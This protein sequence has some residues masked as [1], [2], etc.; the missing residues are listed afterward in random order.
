MFKRKHSILRA[1]GAPLV[2][3]VPALS[4]AEV[5]TSEWACESCPFDQG[6][7]AKVSAG[8]TNVSDDAARFGNYT[9][10]DEEG[11]YGNLDGEGQYAGD[12]YR[13]DYSMEDLG[14]D[15]RAFELSI[16]NKGLFGLDFGYRELPFRRFDTSRTIFSRAASDTLTVPSGWVP[17]GTTS[18]M[19]QLD[20]ALRQQLVGTDRQILDI[21][22]Y[23]DP[24]NAFRVFADFRRQT[25]DGVD[26]TS[27]GTYTQAAFLPR[28][29]DFET[30]QVDAGIEYR[31]DNLFLTLAWY[32]SYFSNKNPSLTWETPF[33]ATPEESSL[34]MAREPDNEFQQISLSGKYRLDAWNTVVA[35]LAAS[36]TGRQ[37]EP[38]LDYTINGNYAGQFDLP[39]ATLD[40]K[41]DTLNYSFT[42]T[43]RP[44]DGLRVKFGYRYDE[45]D[46]RT[47]ISE[48]SRVIV[49]AFPSGEPTENVPYSYDRMHATTTVEYR[50]FDKLRVMGGYE[51]RE[52]NRDF[53]EVAEQTTNTGWG[54]VRWQP[55]AWLDLRAKG[56]QSARGVDRYDENVAV[57]LGQNPLMRKYYLAY[58]YRDFGELVASITPLEAPVSFSASV[59]FADDDYK[60]S[61]VGLNGSEEFRATADVS[62]TVSE[63]AFLYLAW[64][65]DTIDAHQTGAEQSGFWD[66]SAFHED[67]FDHTAIG[68]SWRP[69][70]GK[71]SL[72]VD[73]SRADGE[74]RIA[75]DSLSGG[76]SQLPDLESTLDSTRIEASYA[77]SDRLEGTFSL[78]YERFELEDW[79]LVSP[80]TLP[81][82]LTLGAEPYDYDVYAAG[83]GIRYRFGSAEIKL[84]D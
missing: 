68:F 44:I 23:W 16:R 7:R 24:R 38:L 49:D 51:Y 58:R 76:P 11:T 14:L 71:F 45:R 54:Q 81:T 39:R 40:G 41:V 48:W 69:T 53:Q 35:F 52:V 12:G 30:D 74:T 66:W 77:F 72:S 75:L 70:E 2:L 73:Y 34:R 26:I 9:G 82:I 56:G 67:R 50:V 15:S 62:W 64:G 29:I 84:V 31:K 43:T 28:W 83:L 55:F 46:N 33:L 59:L 78:R 8:A 80:A 25:R 57:S 22:G 79:A 1:L 21:G 37:D 10:Y 3:A 61:L 65:R 63:S 42:L 18:G 6:Y 5:D 17:A 36:G 27:G 47:P 60:D 20:A 32:G 19:T 4:M 13:L